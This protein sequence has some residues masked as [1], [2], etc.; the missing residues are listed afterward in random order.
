MQLPSGLVIGVLGFPVTL[1]GHIQPDLSTLEGFALTLGGQRYRH[2][3]GS[4][5]DI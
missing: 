1:E 5:I 3:R 4:S 2:M